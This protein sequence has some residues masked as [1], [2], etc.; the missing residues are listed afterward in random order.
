MRLKDDCKWT[1][2]KYLEGGSHGIFEEWV[3][4][5]LFPQR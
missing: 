1:A 5:V 2:G 3:P 4:G